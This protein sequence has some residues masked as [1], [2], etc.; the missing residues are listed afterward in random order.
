MVKNLR[1]IA[2]L[3][4]VLFLITLG[5]MNRL[6]LYDGNDDWYQNTYSKI[7]IITSEVSN[8]LTYIGVEVLLDDNTYTYWSN[9]GDSGIEPSIIIKN[10]YINH[11]SINWP[12]PKLLKDEFGTNYI[13]E[14]AVLI[15]ITISLENYKYGDDIVLEMNFGICNLVCIPINQNIVFQL[16]EKQ[17]N[18]SKI[19]Y[20]LIHNALKNIPKYRSDGITFINDIKFNDLTSNDNLQIIFSKKI[21]AIFPLTSEKYFLSDNQSQQENYMNYNYKFRSYIEDFESK[22]I[23]MTF[24]I[25]TEGQYFLEDFIINP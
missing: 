16:D 24:L 8:G 21:D 9:P 23:K 12:T 11:Y 2:N 10:Q 5:V 25:K 18:D 15:P 17:R 14:D 20:K 22:D 1:I 6:V 4:L 3:L 7:R 13:Y 19:R